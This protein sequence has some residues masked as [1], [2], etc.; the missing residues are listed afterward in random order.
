V[1]ALSVDDVVLLAPGTLPKTSSG[2][3]RRNQCRLDYLHDALVP[4]CDYVEIGRSREPGDMNQ[5]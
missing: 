5:H 1:H 2:K 3:V 4:A